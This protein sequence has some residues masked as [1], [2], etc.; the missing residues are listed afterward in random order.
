MVCR[1]YLGQVI[2]GRHFVWEWTIWE[3]IKWSHPFLV[4]GH[5]VHVV[6]AALRRRLSVWLEC[7]D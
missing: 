2:V 4:G 1:E 5:L 3:V 6:A 7:F